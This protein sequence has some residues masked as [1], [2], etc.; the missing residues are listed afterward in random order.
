MKALGAI[1][2]VAGCDHVGSEPPN[3]A[4]YPATIISLKEEAQI[5]SYIDSTRLQ[6]HTFS[7]PL[8]TIHLF[9]FSYF[10]H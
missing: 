4:A 2:V 8:R 9:L 1:G 10:S 5:S 6:Y 7:N 3:S